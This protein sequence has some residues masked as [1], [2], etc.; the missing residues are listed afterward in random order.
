MILLLGLSVPLRLRWLLSESAFENLVR[1]LPATDAPTQAVD[2]PVPQRLGLY[3]LSHAYRQGNGVIFY[4]STGD[5]L[6]DA[7][8][9]Y[10]PTGPF[11]E[12]ESGSFE[13]PRFHH[14]GNAWYSWTASW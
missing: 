10:L 6:D 8:F 13:A 9:A 14:L 7:G 11:P 1:D 2:L 5:F 4:E 3:E 12:L